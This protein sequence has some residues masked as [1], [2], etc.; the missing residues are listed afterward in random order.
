V[1]VTALLSW[2]DERPEDLHR[3]ITSHAAEGVRCIGIER[4]EEYAQIIAARLSQ[5]SL[6]GD[7]EAA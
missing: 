5:L 6:L 2:F 1:K 7:G 4:E 3:A